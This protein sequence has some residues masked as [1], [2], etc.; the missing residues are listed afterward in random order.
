MKSTKK[1]LTRPRRPRGA[2][3]VQHVWAQELG[4][5]ADLGGSPNQIPKYFWSNLGDLPSGKHL[6]NYGKSPFLMGK[7][8]ISMAM[9]NSKLLVYQRV[10]PVDVDVIK[11]DAKWSLILDLCSPISELNWKH[12]Q[13]R[14]HVRRPAEPLELGAR[15]APLWVRWNVARQV[16]LRSWMGFYGEISHVY[17]YIFIFV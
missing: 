7:S 10:F 3:E 12:V 5:A 6:H 16:A 1:T 15:G 13:P 9:F 8:T 17:I 11:T 2:S 4:Y 14:H